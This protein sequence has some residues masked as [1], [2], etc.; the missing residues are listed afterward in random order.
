[1]S[2]NGR[3]WDRSWCLKGRPCRNGEVVGHKG[4]LEGGRGLVLEYM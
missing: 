1:M 2:M 3:V 4:G